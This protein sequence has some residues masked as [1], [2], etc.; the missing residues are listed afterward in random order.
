M[1]AKTYFTERDGRVSKDG[2][3]LQRVAAACG[4]TP[5][6][7]YLVALG[8]KTPSAELACLIEHSTGGYVDRRDTLRDF[9]WDG[10]LVA[11][12]PA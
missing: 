7:L 12:Q 9:P 2:D 8:H 10:P 1:D 11:G 3:E 4:V 6:T 5:G